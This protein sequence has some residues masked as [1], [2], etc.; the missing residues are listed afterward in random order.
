MIEI[1]DWLRKFFQYPEDFDPRF[2]PVIG[3]WR[4]PNLPTHTDPEYT[5]PVLG[6][7]G[8]LSLDYADKS[9]RHMVLHVS[10]RKIIK[11]NPHR[12][13]TELIN[14]PD[15]NYVLYGIYMNLI[16]HLQGH[17]KVKLELIQSC[18]PKKTHLV[19]FR[20]DISQYIIDCRVAEI[21]RKE[22]EKIK[23]PQDGTA[24]L[25]QGSESQ[26]GMFR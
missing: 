19:S 12:M 5:Y 16:A 3:R 4:N 11:D 23:V 15:M 2:Q 22:E 21:A 25:Y 13:S 8:K 10:D 1:Y 26:Y 6:W 18:E 20:S 17:T 7:K 9:W 24:P 14:L